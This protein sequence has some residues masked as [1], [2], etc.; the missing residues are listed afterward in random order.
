MS[1]VIA[2]YRRHSIHGEPGGLFAAEYQR[3]LPGGRRHPYGIFE[4]IL[5]KTGHAVRDPVVGPTRLGA[6]AR[7]QVGWSDGRATLTV[8][9]WGI[10]PTWP[11]FPWPITTDVKKRPAARSQAIALVVATVNI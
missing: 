10:G 9:R 3:R 2:F 8:D 11:F 5:A 6:N 7:R 1:V 4:R